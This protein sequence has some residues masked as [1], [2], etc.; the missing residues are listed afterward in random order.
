[1][2]FIISYACHDIF[3]VLAQFEPKLKFLS[4]EETLV[5]FLWL[6]G[7]GKREEMK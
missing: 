6:V 3:I 5:I 2:V 7:V 1:M 4:I